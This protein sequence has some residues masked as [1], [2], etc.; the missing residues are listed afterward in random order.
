M[1]KPN[2]FCKCQVKSYQNKYLHHEKLVF[3]RHLLLSFPYSGITLTPKDDIFL[4]CSVYVANEMLI[5]RFNWSDVLKSTKI[6]PTYH[7]HTTKNIIAYIPKSVCQ[8]NLV[9]D[10]LKMH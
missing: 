9:Q 1:C 7:Q 2:R 3:D 6:S 4:F 10:K 5:N 8:T